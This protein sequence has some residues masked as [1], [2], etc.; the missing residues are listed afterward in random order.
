MTPNE[1]ARP[2]PP[3]GT[4]STAEVAAGTL[5]GT[6]VGTW[7]IDPMHTAVT[8]AVRHLMSKVRGRFTDVEGSI[9]LGATA[10]ETRVEATIAIGSIDTGVQLRDEDLRSP[11][12][13]DSNHFPSM[14]FQSGQVTEDE[15]GAK[16][17]GTLTIRDTARDVVLDVTFLGLDETGLQGEPRIGFVG[18]TTLRRSDFGVGH[19]PVEGGKVVVGDRVDVE[20]DVEAYL[21]F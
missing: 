2:I 7:T 11:N 1:T 19:G 17:I 20:L 6:P 9:S 3:T 12:F 8:F 15:S 16:M 21:R 5:A 13:F 18:R 10:A 14:R 4:A